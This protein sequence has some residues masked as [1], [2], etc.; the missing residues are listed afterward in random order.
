MVPLLKFLASKRDANLIIMPND[1]RSLAELLK[2]GPLAELGREAQ[3]RRET[4][5]S[6]RT[7]L[8]TD[9]ASHLV[10]ATTNEAGELVLV[11]DSP[12]WA[13]RVRYCTAA[14][15]NQRVIVRVLP[16]GGG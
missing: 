1:P 9:E 12:S 3:R 11:M 15:S 2:S 6:I 7:L 10:S 5:A 16:R 4:T 13:A 8:P 14:L